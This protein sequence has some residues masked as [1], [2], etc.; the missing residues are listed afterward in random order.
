MMQLIPVISIFA[1]IAYK[2]FKDRKIPELAIAL[3]W[4]LYGMSFA[5]FPSDSLVSMMLMLVI[6][7]F[8]LG[9]FWIFHLIIESLYKHGFKRKYTKF[10]RTGL[11]DIFIV[12][13]MLAIIAQFGLGICILWA[14]FTFGYAS[15]WFRDLKPN[16]INRTKQIPLL[17]FAFIA[18]IC[19]LLTLWIGGA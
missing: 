14:V 9:L 1:Y 6:P 10:L 11:A 19:C 18:L 12:P 7:I 2:D 17:A 15:L 4:L 3:S 13:L 16:D 5:F 8:S